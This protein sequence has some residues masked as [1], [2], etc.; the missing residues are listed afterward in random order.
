MSFDLDP[1][2]AADTLFAGHLALCEVRLMDD[3]RFE[4]LVLVPRRPGV[5]ELHDLAADDL[6]RLVGE[7][8]AASRLL[9]ARGA[10]KVNVGALGNLVPQLHVHVVARHPGDEAWPGPVWG[11]GTRRPY[12]EDQGPHRAAELMAA[13]GARAE[14]P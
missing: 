2:L 1:R 10:H 12:A 6:A 7:V 11:A 9:S 13:L 5:R 14:A 8:T 3:V 4:W